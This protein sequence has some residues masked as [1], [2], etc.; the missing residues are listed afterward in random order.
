MRQF[1]TQL[2]T[3]GLKKHMSREDAVH[4]LQ[5]YLEAK[6]L[7]ISR[8]VYFS[9]IVMTLADIRSY[10]QKLPL[11]SDEQDLLNAVA[12]QQLPAYITYRDL[13]FDPANIEE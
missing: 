4:V 10:W 6:R 1:K 12:T 8:E 11:I 7:T 13:P 5:L 2:K 3:W 9:G